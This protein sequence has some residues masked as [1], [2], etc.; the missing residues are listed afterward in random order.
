MFQ[1]DLQIRLI[2]NVRGGKYSVGISLDEYTQE[3][4][5]K[6][7]YYHFSVLLFVLFRVNNTR[8]PKLAICVFVKMLD[9]VSNSSYKRNE[10]PKAICNVNVFSISQ[11][12]IYLSRGQLKV[13]LKVGS[14]RVTNLSLVLSP[15]AVAVGF[16]SRE[17]E[18]YILIKCSSVNRLASI[19]VASVGRSVLS[20][21]DK[22]R[23]SGTYRPRAPR[24]IA[25]GG[26]S[27]PLQLPRYNIIWAHFGFTLQVHT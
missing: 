17:M 11:T 21:G 24:L 18:S 10:Q 25:A 5:H 22:P 6:E 1:R 3:Y 23:R 20:L 19:Q 27:V 12:K 14:G 15:F 16:C 4:P 9:K 2:V 13:L 7:F 8:T 26:I